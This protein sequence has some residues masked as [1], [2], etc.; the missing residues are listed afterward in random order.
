MRKARR[1]RGTDFLPRCWSTGVWPRRWAE[2]RRWPQIGRAPVTLRAHNR[3]L[4]G[5]GAW[6]K[7]TVRA[8]G[9]NLASSTTDDGEDDFP[10][11]LTLSAHARWLARAPMTRYGEE[12][13]LGRSPDRLGRSRRGRLE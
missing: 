7:P 12:E 3:H 13:A 4:A 11:R 6:A 1:T 2:V 8:R 5:P 10:P 9:P